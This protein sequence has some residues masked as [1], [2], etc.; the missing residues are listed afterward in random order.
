LLAAGERINSLFAVTLCLRN[1]T[2]DSAG[3]RISQTEFSLNFS[4]RGLHAMDLCCLLSDGMCVLEVKL[5]MPI[6]NTGDIFERVGIEILF[7]FAEGVIAV[8]ACDVLAVVYL[9]HNGHSIILITH[10]P[11]FIPS[12]SPFA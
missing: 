3:V 1:R 12:L 8:S 10:K 9:A 11:I 6:E 2:N 4:Q 5:V 7:L